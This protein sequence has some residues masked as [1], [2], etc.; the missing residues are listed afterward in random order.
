MVPPLQLISLER[1]SCVAE[2]LW[3]RKGV[4]RRRR[5]ESQNGN[6]SSSKIRDRAIAE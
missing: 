1:E 2:Q 4:S 3:R 6:D 5:E